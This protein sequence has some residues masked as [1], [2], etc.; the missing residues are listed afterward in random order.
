MLAEK[1][2]EGK[3]SF[4]AETI[5]QR[6]IIRHLS[7]HLKKLTKEN[8]V[9]KDTSYLVYVKADIMF[10]CLWVD[11]KTTF[12]KID[13][14]LRK[15]WLECCGHM[16]AFTY[17]KDGLLDKRPKEVPM[18]WRA[19][20]LLA[21]GKKLTY[22]YDYGSTTYLKIEVK[23]E[24]E[25]PAQDAIVLLSRNE[26]LKIMCDVCKEKIATEL[27]EV[28][29]W[30]GEGYYCK[31]CAKKHAKKCEDFDDYARMPIVNS[32]RMGVCGYDGGTIDTERDGVYQS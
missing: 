31:T 16:S 12:T 15:I 21:K 10:L 8:P 30:E 9:E 28:H 5:A 29:L 27:C 17:I 1:K 7:T 6:G 18:K 25:I 11:G 24:L 23:E 4:C 13:S 20:K 14:F 32:P 19:D 22:E 26:P 2:S 3:C